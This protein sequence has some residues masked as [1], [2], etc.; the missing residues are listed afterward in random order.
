MN[1]HIAEVY[2]DPVCRIVTFRL[3][4]GISGSSKSF[5]HIVAEGLNLI[6]VGT[7][8]YDEIVGK[9]RYLADVNDMDILG[10]FVLQSLDG[11]A[12][13]FFCICFCRGI[14]FHIFSLP[15]LL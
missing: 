2:Q 6:F 4:F 13:H 14:I 12:G 9:N 15:S 1:D 10:L 3:F 5:F 11:Q 8:C 7:A